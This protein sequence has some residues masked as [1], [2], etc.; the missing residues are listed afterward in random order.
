VARF[1]NQ[2]KLSLLMVHPLLDFNVTKISEAETSAS[3][4]V[5]FWLP[6]ILLRK[7]SHTPYFPTVRNS[8]LDMCI[9]RYVRSSILLFWLACPPV[10]WRGQNL[11][12]ILEG[13]PT[14]GNDKLWDRVHYE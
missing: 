9:E 6:V 8:I 7:S 1:P 10:F 5:S 4:S 13:F 2:N 14:S 3:T 11:F 12:S